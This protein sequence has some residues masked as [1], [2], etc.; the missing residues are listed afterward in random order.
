MSLELDRP[1][2]I[3]E[4]FLK[5]LAADWKIATENNLFGGLLVK[6]YCVESSIPY[7]PNFRLQTL[8]I[9]TSLPHYQR[10]SARRRVES[11]KI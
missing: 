11:M 7:V 4:Q 10:G 3:F 5:E 8:Q 6:S 2:V 9:G 1:G